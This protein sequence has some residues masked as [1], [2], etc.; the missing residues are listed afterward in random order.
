MAVLESF[1]GR[2]RLRSSARRLASAPG[3]PLSPAGTL[4]C[5]LS[6]LP[7]ARSVPL[8]SWAMVWFLF[9]FPLL[10]IVTM[11]VAHQA[12][13]EARP[14]FDG[15][16]L[17]WLLVIPFIFA[18]LVT[19]QAL[20]W[21]LVLELVRVI[22]R[23]RHG[24]ARAERV[25]SLGVLVA[26]GAFALYTPIRILAEHDRLRVRTFVIDAHPETSDAAVAPFRIAFVA[27]LQQDGHTDQGRADRVIAEVDKM[28]ADVVLGGG[29]WI[30]TGPDYIAAA[31]ASAGRLHSRLGTF[32]VRGDHEHFAY[33]DR[34]R[35]VAE[36]ERALADHDVRMLSNQTIRFEHHG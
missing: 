16:V 14:S 19:L 22:V 21:V 18:V 25:G 24:A 13:W 35:S 11:L 2:D 12:G 5:P 6:F 17:S 15:P 9:G 8:P 30:N 26:L 7:Q 33:I 1:S 3:T 10:M 34:D 4:I 32:T 20:P 28:N 23:R 27:D 31:A 29:D 36:V